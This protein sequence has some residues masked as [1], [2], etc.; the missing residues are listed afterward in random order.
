MC[1]ANAEGVWPSDHPTG[2]RFHSPERNGN[3]SVSEFIAPAVLHPCRV[4]AGVGIAGCALLIAAGFWFLPR[5]CATPLA[6]FFGMCAA[7]LI[8]RLHPKAAYLRLTEKGF[9]YTAWIRPEFARWEEV[10]GFSVVRSGF[11]RRVGWNWSGSNSPLGSSL[12][13]RITG[14]AAALP[15]NYGMKP[16]ALAELMESWRRKD[17]ERQNR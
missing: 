14:C 15:D 12:N 17:A 3:M 9:A 16:E 8:L 7:L 4:R 13:K 1:G 11:Q 10:S 6:A 5:S 2:D